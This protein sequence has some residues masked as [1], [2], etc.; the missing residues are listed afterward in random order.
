VPTN[1]T[2]TVGAAERRAR[3]VTRHRLVPARR[4]DRAVDV[5]RD[6]AALHATDP[7]TVHLA[8]A[9]RLRAP[10]VAAVERALYDDRELVRILGMRRTM[11]VVPVE[12]APVVQA[13]C[14][15]G[16]AAVERRRLVTHIEQGG[17]ATDGEAWLRRVGDATIA[18][19]ERRGEALASELVADVPELQAQIRVGEATRWAVTQRLTNRVLSVLA[20]EEAIVRGRPRGSWTSTQ[21]RWAPRSRWLPDEPGE[22]TLTAAEARAELAR[23]WLA[24]FGPGTP[25]DLKWWA[26][27]TMADAR[28]AL[29]GAGAVAVTLD[30]DTGYVLPDDVDPLPPCEPAV[31]LLPA[32]DPTP[33]GWKARD[34]YLGSHRGPLF[35]R[36]GN[37]GPSIW[38]GGR[39]VGGWA[40]RRDGQVV[41]RLLEDVGREAAAAVTS[42]AQSLTSWLG[43]ARV[44]PRFRTPLERELV[45]AP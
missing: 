10:T 31:A 36:S 25:A 4:A 9:A 13:A 27:W 17:L 15:R 45:G 7:A 24:A 22:V 44:T 5:A 42:E 18:A 34:W 8:A 29:A 37:I 20:A 26:G 16:I 43:P 35:D 41:T 2:R 30:G 11:F 40:Q 3:L 28:S 32:L 23:R 14:T 33:M 21:Y 1:R 38:W 6:L 39:I 19:L 12:L